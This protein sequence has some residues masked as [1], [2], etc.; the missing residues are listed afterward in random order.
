MSNRTWLTHLSRETCEEMIAG[1]S[2]GRLGVMVAGKPEV[3]PI[4][5]VFLDGEIFFPTNDGTKIHAALEWPWVGFEVDGLE[6]ENESGWSVMVSGRAEEITDP[7]TIERAVAMRDSPW[8][9]GPNVR[10]IRITPTEITGRRI[11]SDSSSESLSVES[12][13]ELTKQ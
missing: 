13:P 7:A 3:F 9:K 4:V 5:H 11:E 10:W 12:P 1:A 2:V 6:A 8:R